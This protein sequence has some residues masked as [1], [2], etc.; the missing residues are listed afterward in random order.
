MAINRYRLRSLAKS[1]NRAARYVEILLARPDR[2]IGMILLGNIA[3]HNAS[4]A[5]VTYITLRLFGE[6]WIAVATGL[7]TVLI[8]IFG[9]IAP[10]T[11][12]AVRPER[13]ALPSA[14]IYMPLQW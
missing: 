9:E 1:G 8:L 2:L 6:A 10:K 14:F 7:L 11:W 3:V 4:V 12:G 5:I 13:L